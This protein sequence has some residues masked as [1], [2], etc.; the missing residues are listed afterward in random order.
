VPVAVAVV[1][2]EGSA[3]V[4]RRQKPPLAGLAEFPGGK[5]HPGESPEAAAIREVREE[6]GVEVRVERLLAGGPADYPHG[7]LDLRF[8]L[9]RP[10]PAAE[11]LAPHP[12]FEWVPL[13]ELD[14]LD[15][16]PANAVALRA[17][18]SLMRD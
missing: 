14:R 6:A 15:F 3:L 5:I 17:L 2:H 9:C 12:P 8:Y 16:P 18:R 7:R 4:G 1:L 10:G 11:A 13:E